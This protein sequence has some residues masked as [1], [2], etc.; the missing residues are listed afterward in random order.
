MYDRV[1][2]PYH[3]DA[4]PH[5]DSDS[6]YHRIQLITLMRIRMWIRILNFI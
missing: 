6:T 3:V 5:A 4:D 2:D 1:V